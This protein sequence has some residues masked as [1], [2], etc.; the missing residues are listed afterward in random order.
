MLYSERR[1]ILVEALQHYLG[2]RLTIVGE[3]AGMHLMVRFNTEMSDETVVYR[4]AQMDISLTSTQPFYL[5][6]NKVNE[7]VFGYAS[8]KPEQI[9]EGIRRLTQC[10]TVV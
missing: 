6:P 5:N 2:R 3:N 1:K 10:L 4:A 8:L 7:F 9:V